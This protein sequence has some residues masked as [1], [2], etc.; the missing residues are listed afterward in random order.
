MTN[1]AL[2]DL[3]A[4]WNYTADAWSEEQADKYYRTLIDSFQLLA[5]RPQFGKA[6]DEILVGLRGLPCE[7]HVIFYRPAES[8]LIEI[9][10]ILHGRMD[11]KRRVEE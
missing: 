2:D 1:K 9:I 4:I 11:L 3:G 6:Y 8:D 5:D 10:R 7:K